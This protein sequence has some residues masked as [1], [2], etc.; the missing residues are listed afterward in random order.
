MI[1]CVTPNPAIDRTFYVP[2]YETHAVNRAA[3]SLTT[4]GGKGLNVARAART[5]G[6]EVLCMGPLGGN[7][8]KTLAWLTSSEGLAAHW[9]WIS[10]ETRNCVIVVDERSG[11]STVI[12]DRGPT[13]TAGEWVQLEFDVMLKAK[14]ATTVCISGSLTPAA[15]LSSFAQLVALLITAGKKVWVDTNGE[16]LHHAAA[17]KG[18]RLRV[19]SDEAGT[20]LGRRLSSD[21]EV[22]EAARLLSQRT[23]A[24][25]VI[26]QGS[27]TV[28]F[29]SGHELVSLT[30]PRMPIV[31]AVG[32]GDSFLAGLVT[33][34]EQDR[35][36]IEA[37]R[38]AVAAGTANALAGGAAQ[39]TRAGVEAVLADLSVH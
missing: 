30:P 25:V 1:I 6:A 22:G 39:F 8:G 20:L 2:H 12:N 17:V 4:A 16:A 29:A 19:N 9:T 10:G 32:S 34:L 37:L 21:N 24:P 23:G 11:R 15:N 14:S 38:W 35:P 36:L 33:A 18:I 31:N 7:H 13:L 28:F 27:G 5:L 3:R 26:T